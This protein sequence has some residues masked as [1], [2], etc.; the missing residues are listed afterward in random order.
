LQP[1]FARLRERVANDL[2]RNAVDLQIELDAGN[3]ALRA[4]D[5]EVH[6]AEM[7]FIAHDVGEQDVAAWLFDKT[8][9]YAG[10]RIGNWHAGVHQR[11][12]S[13]A[14]RGHARRTVGLENFRHETNRVRELG[15][16]RQ[17]RLERALGQHTVADFAP[18]GA[19]N[20]PAFAYAKWREV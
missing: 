2:F 5:L 4:G 1:R 14:Y 10:H 13:T 6:I 7:V 8:N 9:G 11:K 15:R 19:A 3:A 12:C 16:G 17:H 18:T 20:G